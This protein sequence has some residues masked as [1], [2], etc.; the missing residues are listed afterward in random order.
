[1]IIGFSGKK[2]VGKTTAA[3]YLMKHY[4]FKVKSFADSLRDKSKLFF[5]FKDTDFSVSNKEKPF[6]DYDWTPRDFQVN[7]GEMVRYHDPDYWVKQLKLDRVYDYAIDDVRYPN[8]AEYIRKMGGV[9]VRVERYA[10]L[11]P[12]GPPAQV[13]S[14]TALDGAKF[15]HI[16]EE[17][18]NTTL[19]DLQYNVG[20]IM[21]I[22]GK[23]KSSV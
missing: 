14:E 3:V 11:N 7:L 4:G 21:K 17:P 16:I 1:M 20:L 2:G 13:P 22:L 10:S 19:E 12:Y 5:P 18:Y 8:E 23:R 6:L 15:E 9:I